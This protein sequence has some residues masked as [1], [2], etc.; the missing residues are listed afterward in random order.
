M[1]VDND[2]ALSGRTTGLQGVELSLEAIVGGG[3]NQESLDVRE[4]Q[5][6]IRDGLIKALHELLL[7]RRRQRGYRGA[8]KI[9]TAVELPIQ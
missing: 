3:L 8:R 2:A 7:V 4:L 6:G 1:R 5:R 9:D